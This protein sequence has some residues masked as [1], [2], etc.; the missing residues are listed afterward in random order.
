MWCAPLL[1]LGEAGR[2]GQRKSERVTVCVCVC[3]GGGGYVL[4]LGG[5]A[6]GVVE[7][8]LDFGL[9]VGTLVGWLCCV[10]ARRARARLSDRLNSASI[11]Q[12][13]GRRKDP[14]PPK[15]SKK[16]PVPNRNLRSPTIS[17]NSSPSHAP[18]LPHPLQCPRT[19]AVMVPGRCESTCTTQTLLI[20]CRSFVAVWPAEQG[21]ELQCAPRRGKKREGRQGQIRGYSCHE[22]G[23][24]G[25]GGKQHLCECLCDFADKRR[26]Q[27]QCR[28][29]VYRAP[30][31]LPPPAAAVAR[32]ARR[33]AGGRD[34]AGVRD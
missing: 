29:L 34:R 26:F 28:C 7:G 18:P 8:E 17:L 21:C 32:L 27:D 19:S 33:G 25:G 13:S 6:T 4:G 11:H 10:E 1:P 12:T 31:S 16:S 30:S 22:A 5:E 20:Q 15:R 9:R 14:L 24:G 2:V 23:G 3:V